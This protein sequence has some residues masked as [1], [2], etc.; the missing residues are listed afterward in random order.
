VRDADAVTSRLRAWWRSL[1]EVP[2]PAADAGARALV[3][4][5]RRATKSGSLSVYGDSFG[6]PADNVHSVIGAE[7]EPDNCALLLFDEYETLRVW[8]PDGIHVDS[9]E[10]RIDHASRVRWEWYS[11]GDPR[12]PENLYFIDHH[13]VGD[14]VEVSTNARWGSY[15]PL[16][17]HPAVQLLDGLA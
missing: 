12:T 10:F 14:N 17:S 5:A 16:L 1:D 11:Y 7:V 4:A 8:D 13:V 15:G 6:R 9:G 2:E 3:K